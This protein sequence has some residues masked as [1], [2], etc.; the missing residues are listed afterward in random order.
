[1]S[2]YDPQNVERRLEAINALHSFN[3][4]VGPKLLDYYKDKPSGKE[5][6]GDNI[7]R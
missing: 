3:N 4:I 1:M 6:E 7:K 2:K 5:F